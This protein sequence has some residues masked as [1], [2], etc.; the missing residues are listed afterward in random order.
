M[1]IF[2]LQ[3]EMRV[4]FYNCLDLNLMLVTLYIAKAATIDA[5]YIEIECYLHSSEAVFWFDCL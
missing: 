3:I 5:V 4:D 2:D 1:L